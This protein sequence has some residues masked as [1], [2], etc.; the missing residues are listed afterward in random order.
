MTVSSGEQTARGTL[1]YL[2]KTGKGQG[3]KRAQA[4]YTWYPNVYEHTTTS[5]SQT[6]ANVQP[7]LTTSPTPDSWWEDFSR[8]VTVEEGG[9]GAKSDETVV[10][11]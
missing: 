5:A 8:A 1:A 4:T 7:R 10:I 2:D 11:N 9:G 3:K 6:N